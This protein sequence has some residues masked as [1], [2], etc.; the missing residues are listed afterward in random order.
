MKKIFSLCIALTL[1]LTLFTFNVSALNDQSDANIIHFDDG[2]CLEISA[3]EETTIARAT[4]TKSGQ[5]SLIYRNNNGVEQWRATLTATFTYNGSSATCTSASITSS[6]SDGNWKFTQK[7]AT[8]SGNKATG[9]ITVKHY[10]LGIP[11]KTVEQTITITCSASG[12][13]S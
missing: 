7:T 12:A 1:T 6:V 8:K 3:V 10:V 5:Q 13:L 4:N 2:S 9:N 11:T